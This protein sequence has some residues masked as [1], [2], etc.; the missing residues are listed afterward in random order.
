MLGGI[1]IILSNLIMSKFALSVGKFSRFSS[2]ISTTKSFQRSSV[3]Y[4]CNSGTNIRALLEGDERMDKI[5]SLDGW[6]E[7]SDRDAIQKTYLFKDFIQVSVIKKKSCY[8]LSEVSYNQQHAHLFYY[9]IL[10]RHL[11]GCLRSR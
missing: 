10:Y 4:S 11:V 9:L 6:V 1:F 2:I 3:L 5:K 8:A 7:L